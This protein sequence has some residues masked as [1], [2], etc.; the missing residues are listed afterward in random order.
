[1]TASPGRAGVEIPQTVL[2]LIKETA[3]SMR[4]GEIRIEIRAD[5][6]RKV[7]VVVESR[8]RFDVEEAQ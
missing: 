8:E 1:M 4:Y 3:R 5:R 6:P 7:D 2:D